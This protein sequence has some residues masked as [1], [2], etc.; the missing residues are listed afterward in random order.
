MQAP[1]VQDL[2]MHPM[3]IDLNGLAQHQEKNPQEVILNP[4]QP[5][6][7]FLELSDLLEGNVVVEEVILAQNIQGNVLP[8]M[9]PKEQLLL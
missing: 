4:A 7:E 3:E 2:N 6:G 1:V 5:Q 9:L 8:L